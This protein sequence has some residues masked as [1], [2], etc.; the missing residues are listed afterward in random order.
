MGKSF[1]PPARPS[2]KLLIQELGDEMLVY[3]CSRHKVF[4]LNPSTSLVWK[5]CDGKTKR[6]DVERLL[7]EQMHLTGSRELK[8]ALVRLEQCQLI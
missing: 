6:V 7:S 5:H 1:L 4:Y 8:L 3:D 2:E